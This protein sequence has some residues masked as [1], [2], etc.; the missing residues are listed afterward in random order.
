MLKPEARGA[1]PPHWLCPNCYNQGK[2]AFYQPTGAMLQRAR[3]YRCQ[4]CQGNLSVESDLKWLDESPASASLSAKPKM[5]GEIC[6]KCGEAEFRIESSSRH[7]LFGNMG[8]VNH[9]M[10]CDSCGFAEMRLIDPK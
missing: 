10:K 2:K 1:E 3:V 5:R 9:H 7:P 4:G 6:P 8:G